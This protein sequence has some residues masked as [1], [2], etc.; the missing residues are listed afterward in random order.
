MGNVYD[1]LTAV[2]MIL[3]LLKHRIGLTRKRCDA[4]QK[5]NPGPLIRAL[6]NASTPY[7]FP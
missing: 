5:T 7:S 6:Q 2:F 1:K 4:Q 3:P